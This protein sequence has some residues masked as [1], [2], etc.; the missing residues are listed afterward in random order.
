[1]NFREKTKRRNVRG[2]LYQARR[3]WGVPAKLVRE[4]SGVF[5]TK[6]GKSSPTRVYHDIRQFVTWQA[7]T[8]QKFEYDM[9]YVAANKNF[10]YGGLFEVGDRVAIIDRADL[11]LEI[12][13]SDWIIYDS[14]RFTIKRLTELDFNVGYMLHLRVLAQDPPYQVIDK[15]VIHVVSV[16]QEVT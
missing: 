14:K 15:E 9:S 7:M 3:Q 2:I 13:L 10:T 16:E 12:K 1:M 11:D 8:A 6:T 4:T 5:D